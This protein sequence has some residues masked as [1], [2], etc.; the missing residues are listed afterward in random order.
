MRLV[1]KYLLIHFSWLLS[2]ITVSNQLIMKP[3]IVGLP[4]QRRYFGCHVIIRLLHA[5]LGHRNSSVALPGPPTFTM[6]IGY[7]T[8]LNLK[9]INSSNL[10]I[11]VIIRATE[12]IF[13]CVTIV[14]TS[15]IHPHLTFGICILWC[16]TRQSY[17]IR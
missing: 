2:V 17:T 11:R 10:L 12:M 3:H 9:I 16:M 8:L 13:I 7:I 14:S 15:I 4:W 5:R 1:Y 6:P